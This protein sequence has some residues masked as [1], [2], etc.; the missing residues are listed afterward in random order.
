MCI[1]RNVSP[2]FFAHIEGA[3]MGSPVSPVNVATLFMED[4]EGKALEA[5]QYPPKYWGRYID[6]ARASQ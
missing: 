4:C 5:Y 1:M 3:A 2:P 6:D